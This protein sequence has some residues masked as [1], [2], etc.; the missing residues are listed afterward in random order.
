MTHFYIICQYLKLKLRNTNNSIRNSFEKKYKMTNNRMNNILISMNSIIS[1][2][3]TYN[4]D[5]WSK[6]M[7]V[8]ILV[9]THK[10]KDI[11]ISLDFIIMIC[12][13]SI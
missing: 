10:L 3:E 4:Y 11:L 13:L 1:E 6:Y 2:I 8:L 12:G 5:F 7:I 9:I